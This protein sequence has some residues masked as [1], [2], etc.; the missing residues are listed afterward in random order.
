MSEADGSVKSE[1]GSSWE[2][3][4]ARVVRICSEDSGICAAGP[5]LKPGLL[6]WEHSFPVD[7]LIYELCA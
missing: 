4:L 2:R 6:A 1:S 3:H 7:D 5:A